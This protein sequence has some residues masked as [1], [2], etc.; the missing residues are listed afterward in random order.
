MKKAIVSLSVIFALCTP[1]FA[2]PGIRVSKDAGKIT[3]LKDVS[4]ELPDDMGTFRFYGKERFRWSLWDYAQS[5]P[6][7]NEYDYFS[8]QLR[9]GS[10]FENALFKAHAAWQYVQLWNLPTGASAGA[11]AGAAYFSNGI[12]EKE[13]HATYLKYLEL[14]LKDI[15]KTGIV[16]SVGRFEYSSGYQY[17]GPTDTPEAK[18]LDWIKSKRISERVIGGFE[19]SEYQRS[20]DGV[21]AAW[22][23]DPLHLSVAA[24]SPTQGGFE[25]K[26]SAGI[27]DIRLI[28]TELT[29][30]KD[31]FVTGTELQFFH[32]HYEDARLLSAT[33]ARPD[34]TGRFAVS[35]F[36]NDV[37]LDMIG[38][39]AAGA[40]ALGE[41][42]LDAL[43][44][45][46]WQTGEWFELDHDAYALAAEVGYQWS[47]LPWKPWV[48]GGYNLASG[49]SDASDGSHD[50]FYQ[51][52]PTVRL[53]SS[54][55]LYNAMNLEDVFVTLAVKPCAVI[56]VKTDA[57]FLSLSERTDRWYL[58]SGAMNRNKLTDYTARAS[59][60]NDDLGV[61]WD[62]TLTWDIHP[63]VTASAYYGHLFGGDVVKS[64]YTDQKDVNFFSLEFAVNF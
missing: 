46:G 61:L 9:L 28:A 21:K 57:H 48:R 53:Y 33:A 52:L 64:F 4:A 63:D 2:E 31:K 3:T 39:H 36:E 8:S 24:M 41:G 15:W 26:A 14:S 60:G 22:D 1:A 20:F 45:G 58:G 56:S 40:W 18:K 47:K 34:N 44:W 35:G 30:K 5:A 25:E 11:G 62:V 6:F 54:S 59:N 27:E 32:Y 16:P 51:M 50:T 49:D 38:G 55:I 29:L 7:H 19:W 42:T 23:T 12:S 37:N 43:V 13:S 17:K 10:R